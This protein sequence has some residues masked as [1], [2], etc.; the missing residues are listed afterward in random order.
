MSARILPVILA[1]GKGTRLWPLSRAAGPKQFIKLTGQRTMFQE[2]LLRVNDPELYEAA[3]VLT[4]DDFRFFVTEQA[5]E[6]GVTL[7]AILLEPV[8]RNTAVAIACAALAAQ[9]RQGGDAIMHILASDHEIMADQNYFDSVRV[10]RDTAK[11]GKIVT[12]GIK[13]TEP[14]TGY[15]YI[16]IGSAISTG[17]HAVK[18]FIEKPALEE[19]KAMLA[20]GFYCWNSGMFAC[21]TS[22]LLAE[23]EAH[24]PDVLRA[25]AGAMS[26]AEADLEFTRLD[27]EAFT[28]SPNI[29]I[30]YAVMEKTSNAA[31]VPSSFAWSDLGSWEAVWKTGQR[32]GDGNFSVGAVTLADTKNSLVISRGAHLAV[33]GLDGMAVIASEDAVY[34][35]RLQDSQGV[36]GLV[37][38]LAA[39]PQTAAL[40]QTHPTT[41]RPWGGY[42][43]VLKGERF[44]VKRIFV[45]PGK[46]LSLQ[47][48]RHRSEHW[49]IVRGTAE[50][51]V[52][53]VS[54]TVYENESI[55]IPIG[56]LHRLANNGKIMLELIEVQTGAYLGEDDIV[57]IEDE[58]GRH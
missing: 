8:A 45:L 32:N 13:P 51:I 48:H 35:G 46:T 17:A 39:A 54:K 34:V 18:R 33:Q 7:S 31:V 37:N 40:T 1:G 29:S 20:E 24:A 55:Y 56:E 22:H 4:N 36:G 16:E 57:R 41:Y 19:A 23:L 38:L 2:A 53:N 28:S 58:Y 26:K 11:L 14:A 5:R 15:G 50:V 27:V 3:I 43:S 47:R 6:I 30:D 52:G 12:F 49:I 21:K 25:A 42:T 44:Q 10:A 9:A